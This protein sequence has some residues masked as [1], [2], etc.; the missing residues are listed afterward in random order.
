MVVV[1]TPTRG[2]SYSQAASSKPDLNNLIKDLVPQIIDA[3]KD[4]FAPKL[5]PATNIFTTPSIPATQKSTTRPRTESA[6]CR[7]SA[8]STVE[9]EKRLRDSPTESEYTTSD[10][11]ITKKK[12]GWP[13]GKPRSSACDKDLHSSDHFPIIIT[14]QKTRRECRC[15]ERW[16]CKKAEWAKY[17]SY[18]NAPTSTGDDIDD[19]VENFTNNLNLAASQS[20]PKIQPTVRKTSVPWWNHNICQAIAERKSALKI[21]RINCTQEN[22]I[23]FKKARA[24]A[25]RLISESEKSTWSNYVSS[26]TTTT[27]I[28]EVWRKAKAISGNNHQQSTEALESEGQLITSPPV[29]CE[30]LAD[31]FQATSSSDFEL[32]FEEHFQIRKATE[33]TLVLNFNTDNDYEYNQLFTIDEFENALNGFLNFEHKRKEP[34]YKATPPLIFEESYLLLKNNNK[35]CFEQWMRGGQESTTTSVEVVMDTQPDVKTFTWSRENTLQ[36]LDLY[37]KYRNEVGSFQIRNFK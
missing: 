7:K 14:T 36:L 32:N 6:G 2:L 34:I 30:T 12:K 9:S 15:N 22:L 17:T 10:P 28:S 11:Q 33:E 29:I 18:F 1:P 25:R 20:I 8:A 16:L 26:I 5:P 13:K 3:L 4:T 31:H 21:F 19:L 24:K 35:D 37:K 23:N 27:P